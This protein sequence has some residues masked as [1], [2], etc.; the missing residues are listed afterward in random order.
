MGRSAKIRARRRRRLMLRS[1][2]SGWVNGVTPSNE[3]LDGLIAD[4]P[5]IFICYG[6][7]AVGSAPCHA[8]CPDE[9][10]YGSQC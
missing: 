7:G 4:N 3:V 6:C 5:G 9:E 10:A 2:L 1:Y 8:R